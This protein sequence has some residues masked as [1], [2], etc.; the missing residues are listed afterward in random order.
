MEST[1]NEAR[2]EE[3]T[4]GFTDQLRGRL[5]EE[6]VPEEKANEMAKR[7]DMIETAINELISN[8]GREYINNLPAKEAEDMLMWRFREVLIDPR[9]IE[10]HKMLSK[11]DVQN[12]INYMKVRGYES[13][14]LMRRKERNPVPRIEEVLMGCYSEQI[15]NHT[16]DAVRVLREKGYNTVESGFRPPYEKGIQFFHIVSDRKMDFSS[17]LIEQIKK[18]YGVIITA[19]QKGS[20][21]YVQFETAENAVKQLSEWNRCLTAFAEKLPAIGEVGFTKNGGT[22]NFA[23]E[24]VKTIPKEDIMATAKTENQKRL[25][26]KLYACSDRSEI[27]QLIGVDG[28]QEGEDREKRENP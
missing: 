2:R 7:I 21:I 27:E 17:D 14:D 3:N 16:R 5:R 12:L 8:E 23:E 25:I 20:E 1:Q 22:V 24:I 4:K 6:G 11:N 9:S 10:R 15:E 28:S 19:E 26:E 13:K 18:E